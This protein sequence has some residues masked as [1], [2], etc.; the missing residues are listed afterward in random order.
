RA[1]AGHADSRG[2]AEHRSVGGADQVGAILGEELVGPEVQGRPGVGTAIDVGVV[3]AGPVHEEAV[4][5]LPVPSEAETG[6]LP[7]GPGRALDARRHPPGSSKSPPGCPTRPA[8]DEDRLTARDTM[9][10]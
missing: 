4:D 9:I 10:G 3:D 7:P 2:G 1:G 8:R 6:R 5:D